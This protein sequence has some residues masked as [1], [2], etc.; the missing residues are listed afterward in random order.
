MKVP[1][2]FARKCC[3]CKKNKNLLFI[4]DYGIY[5]EEH[6]RFAYH[7]KC[8]QKISTDPEKYGHIE[9]DL[10]LHIIDLIKIYEKAIEQVKNNKKEKDKLLQEY[11]D[12]IPWWELEKFKL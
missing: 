6:S 3:F 8:L 10:A 7:E 1:W 5:G 9:V 2:K 11:S 4:P 12:R